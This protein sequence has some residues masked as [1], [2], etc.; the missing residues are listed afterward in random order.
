MTFFLKARK[1]VSESASIEKYG[2]S[3]GFL[4]SSVKFKRKRKCLEEEIS[5][6]CR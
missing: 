3:F 5:G 2:R 4:S 1:S 6:F